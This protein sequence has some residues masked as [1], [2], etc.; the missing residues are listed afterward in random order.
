MKIK[1]FFLQPVSHGNYFEN[2]PGSTGVPK[3]HRRVRE[4]FFFFLPFRKCI[5][6]Q[7]R[8]MHFLKSKKKKKKCIAIWPW[9]NNLEIAIW[10][11]N[12]V[13]KCCMSGHVTT[14]IIQLLDV[15]GHKWVLVKS[16]KFYHCQ[17]TSSNFPLLCSMWHSL[18]KQRSLLMVKI[19][20]L[21]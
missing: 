10:S 11:W 8:T 12:R 6:I 1:R 15:P 17:N 9:N 7:F 19:S 20:A 14:R 18:A 5:V 4:Y 13:R 21:S 16:L 2:L 3:F